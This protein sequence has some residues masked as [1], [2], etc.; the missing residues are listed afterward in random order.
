[1][2]KYIF[3]LFSIIVLS[4]CPKAI[5]T[6]DD[7]NHFVYDLM[8]EYYF[9]YKK[10]PDMRE[11]EIKSYSDPAYLLE[12]LKYQ[13]IDRWS[14]IEEVLQVKSTN[15]GAYYQGYGFI[16]FIYDDKK[17]KVAYVYKTSEAWQK[18]LRRG[19]IIEVYNGY[20]IANLSSY[21]NITFYSDSDGDEI[22]LV[23]KKSDGTKVDMT[24][25]NTVVLQDEILHYDVI[26]SNDKKIGYLAFDQ[27]MDFNNDSIQSVISY[28]KS[29]MVNELV[30]DFRYNGGGDMKVMDNL[31]N[32]LIPLS[33][34]SDFAYKFKHNDKMVSEDS[35]VYF[36]ANDNNL[37]LTRLFVLTSENTASASEL[38][39]SALNPYMDV[40]TIGDVTHGKPVGMYVFEYEKYEIAPIC[41]VTFNS[42]NFGEYYDGLTPTTYA[43]DDLTKQLGD[44]KELLFSKAIN[45]IN[46]GSWDTNIALSAK[47]TG[48]NV[49]WG[50]ARVQNM[51]VKRD[52]ELLFQY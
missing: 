21:D 32:S 25:T 18:G 40:Y 41:F 27:F 26:T 34:K 9:W 22:S 33:H 1:M 44:E 5:T 20:T 39:I 36:K 7:V 4:S 37:N 28:F 31:L 48:S 47:T 50:N 30:L 24:L 42:V 52:S 14:Y 19:D 23:I 17:L 51:K 35:S 13:T 16:P 12:D 43:K 29:E 45:F 15:S 49:L 2:R 10:V 3:F 46:T 11:S 38:L 6:P 8:H